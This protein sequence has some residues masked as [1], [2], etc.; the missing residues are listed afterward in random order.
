MSE[1]VVFS[2]EIVVPYTGELV[3]PN[4]PAQCAKIWTEVKELEAQI[5][6][7]KGYL[8]HALMEESRR[9]ETKTLHYP[10]VEITINTP[11][12]ISWDHDVLAELQAAGLPEERFN[13]LVMMEI[14]Y[15]INGSV[16]KSIAASNEVYKE[17]LERA[18]TRVPRSPSVS[19]KTKGA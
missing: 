3:D 8:G 11:S 18:Q 10:G 16:A 13:A 7:L 19:V 5:R 12:E 1:E 2:T 15:K 6:E 9:Q 14:S 17:I 4:D